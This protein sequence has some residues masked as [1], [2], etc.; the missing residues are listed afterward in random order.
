MRFFE[1]VGN[2]DGD[3]QQLVGGKRPFPSPI[4]QRFPLQKL[5][6]QV[7]QNFLQIPNWWFTAGTPEPD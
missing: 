3:G 7:R 5:H 1:R 6:H 2:L 4:G